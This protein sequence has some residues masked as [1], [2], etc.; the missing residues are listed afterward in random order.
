MPTPSGH[1]TAIAAS[2]VIG[3]AVKDASG[4]TLGHVKDIVL[5]KMSNQILFSVIGFGGFLKIGEK[6][7]PL[8]WSALD[9]RPED[10]SYV[11]AI[12]EEQ[13]QNAPADSIE[14]LTS[15]DGQAIFHRVNDYYSQTPGAR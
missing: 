11:V 12:T 5:D 9:Y 8:P 3:T 14:A 7:H 4:R 2:K 10:S 15:G 6:Y 1:T 13:L